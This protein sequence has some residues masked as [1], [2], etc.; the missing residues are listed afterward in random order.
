[1]RKKHVSLSCR[2][3]VEGKPCTVCHEW[4]PVSRFNIDSRGLG[5]RRSRCKRCDNRYKSMSLKRAA[6]IDS[7]LPCP[8]WFVRHRKMDKLRQMRLNDRARGWDTMSKDEFDDITSRPC[9][10]C[11]VTDR[12]GIDRIDNSKGHS[13]DNALPCCGM[14][15]AVRN[16]TFTVDEMKVLGAAIARIRDR[17]GGVLE[18][19]Q[20][21][22]TRS[23]YRPM[24]SEAEMARY[25]IQG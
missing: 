15:N 23:N 11:G 4:T 14:C 12:I 5:G 7:A 2:L 8:H 13:A 9:L 25:R 18:W 1:M 6:R 19:H 20:H 16:S 21:H 22:V 3:G 24:P 10:Y 17:R